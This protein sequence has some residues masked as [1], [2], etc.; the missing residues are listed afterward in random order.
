M[1]RK[2]L[3]EDVDEKE[4]KHAYRL[5]KEEREV[6]IGK[7]ETE[8]VWHVYTTSLPVMRRLDKWAKCT[9]EIRM[10]G[11][12]IGKEY[13]VPK[14]SVGIH[15]PRKVTDAARQRG[16]NLSLTRRESAQISDSAPVEV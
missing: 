1:T 14:A 16:L 7:D 4:P 12:I 3:N 11:E 2:S 10:G 8:D 15:K 6:I 13:E 9:K 5:T